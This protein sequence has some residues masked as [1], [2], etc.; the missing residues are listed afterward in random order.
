MC[1]EGE[2]AWESAGVENA[3]GWVGKLGVGGGMGCEPK[4]L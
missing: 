2:T 4:L 1:L 3:V